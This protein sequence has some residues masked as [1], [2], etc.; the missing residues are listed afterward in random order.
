MLLMRLDT[1]PAGLSP[2][3][4]EQFYKRLIERSGEVPGLKSAALSFFIPFTFNLRQQNVIPEGSLFAPGQQTASVLASTVDTHFFETFRIP[5]LKGREFR[6]TDLSNSPRVAVVNDVFAHRYF[7]DDPIGK[8][9][10][11]TD[12][13]GPW[14]EVIGVAA[15]SKYLALAEPPTGFLYLPLTQDAQQRL[16]L[17][18]ESEADPAALAAPLRELVRSIDPKVPIFGVRT[19]DDIYQQTLRSNLQFGTIMFTSIGVMGLVLA[20]SGLYAVVA[21]QVG[22]RT[23]EIGIRMALGA[24]RLQVMKMVLTQAAAVALIGISIGLA[25]SLASGPAMRQGRPPSHLEPWLFILMP[26][27]LLVVTMLAAAVPARRAS[28]I[29]PQQALRQE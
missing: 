5:I 27:G 18:G 11:L 15:A 3:Q 21:Y 22:R 2:E 10:R 20:V 29:D 7:K 8:R 17:I 19:M 4:S 26:A 28:R 6:P 24:E 12:Q 9:I 1:E 14:V 23:R 25:L 16:T 13:N